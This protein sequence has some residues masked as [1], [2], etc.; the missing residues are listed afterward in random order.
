MFDFLVYILSPANFEPHGAH[1]V[2]TPVLFWIFVVAN[3]V[4]WLAYT[5]IPIAIFYFVRK[6]K[7]MVFRWV[8]VFFGLFIVLCGIHHLLHAITFFYPIYGLEA[9]DDVLMAIVSIGTFI[10]VW[11]VLPDAVQLRSPTELEEANFQL[12]Q[13][14][15]TITQTLNDLHAKTQELERVNKT[16]V[17]RELK[18]IELKKEIEALRANVKK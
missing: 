11:Y 16:M 12:R 2:N 10:G 6:R 18:M 7:D 1:F 14:E 9:I 15:A 3:L 8:F 5:L 4:T 13:N 17:G